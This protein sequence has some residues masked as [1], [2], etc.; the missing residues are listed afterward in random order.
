MP[1]SPIDL[2]T[3]TRRVLDSMP[4]LACDRCSLAD[5]LDAVAA[6]ELRAMVDAP[7]APSSLKDGYALRSAD[8]AAASPENPVRLALVGVAAAG[9]KTLPRLASRSTVRIFTGACI[10][11]AADAVVAEEN[12]RLENGRLLL[13]QPIR[14][15]NDILRQGADVSTGEILVRAGQ[16]LT[17]G[18]LG[19]LAAGGYSQIAVYRRP[20]VAII[21]TG[22][23]VRLPGQT[24]A[25][26]QLY[27][28]NAIT[29]EAWCRQW[30]C[31]TA[32]TVVPDRIEAILAALREAVSTSDLVITSGG[33]WKGERDVV[34]PA[35][36][37]LE[38]RLMFR[39]VRMIPGKGTAMG[40]VGPSPVFMLPGGPPGNLA[41]FLKLALPALR[42]IG[43]RM[44][45]GLPRQSVH[46][47]DEI[48]GRRDATRIVFGRLRFDRHNK[49][50]FQRNHRS[51]RLNALAQA[52]AV[53]T[54]PEG[55]ER[56]RSG[57]R[58]VVDWLR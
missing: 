12:T 44:Q 42:K 10:P 49:V 11:P 15:G 36:E 20:R 43:G 51:R 5:G 34:A 14:A 50:W 32:M 40:F 2:E 7:S 26:G 41:A 28:S 1:T 24:I 3:A 47:E 6:E 37:A 17:P 8:T 25:K 27:A 33:A 38:W 54:V 31:K 4:S 9:G 29:L 22:D 16:R 39:H 45:S 58:V 55:T 18:R 53:L 46:L 52:Q 35:L 21:A 30:H 13:T 57:T 48:H 23:E 56:I 19:V